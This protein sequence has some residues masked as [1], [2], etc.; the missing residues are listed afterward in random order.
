MNSQY[1]IFQIDV[2]LKITNIGKSNRK[3]IKYC[4]CTKNY[5]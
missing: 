4:K 3:K 5:F 2:K 1:R